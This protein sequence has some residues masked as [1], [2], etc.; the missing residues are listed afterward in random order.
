MLKKGTRV[1]V[2]Y[3]GFLSDGTMFDSSEGKEPLLFTIGEGS[4]ISGFEK[5]VVGMKAGDTKT[6]TIPAAEA[7]GPHQENMVLV[8]GRNNLP[9]GMSPVVG[10]KLQTRDSRGETVIVTVTEVTDT[11]ITVDANHELAG[12]D[13]TFEIK[14]ISATP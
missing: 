2:H 6:V 7:Y 11:A 5:A 10:D 8:V 1:V 3:R 9:P 4:M 14:L 12:K 13:L